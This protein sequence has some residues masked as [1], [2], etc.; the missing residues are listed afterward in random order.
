M[1]NQS[2]NEVAAGHNSRNLVLCDQLRTKG[3]DLEASRTIDLYFWADNKQSAQ[4]LR[5][6]LKERGFRKPR[7]DPTDD[8]HVWN[9]EA[10]IEASILHVTNPEFV[11][12]MCE[13]ALINGSKFDG[14]G[15]GPANR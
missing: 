7:K 2:I 1:G 10:N 13:L 3:M 14:W 5:F 15:L 9:V 12:E 8:S 6:A 11:Q 4:Q